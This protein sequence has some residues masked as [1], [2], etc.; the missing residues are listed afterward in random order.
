MTERISACPFRPAWATRSPRRRTR[1]QPSPG[2]PGELGCDR[3]GYTRKQLWCEPCIPR[4]PW[5]TL[6]RI[7]QLRARQQRR[8]PAPR[9][10]LLARRTRAA[11][12]LHPG[13]RGL[14][15]LTR[16]P[17][18]RRATPIFSVGWD[19]SA[20]LNLVP[21]GASTARRPASTSCCVGWCVADPRCAATSSPEL[22]PSTRSTGSVDPMAPRLADAL[23]RAL[24]VRRSPSVRRLAPE[25][26]SSS[27]TRSPSRAAST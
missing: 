17:C 23:A 9:T 7:C 15:P 25:E 11:I 4:L 18:C 6:E 24:P 19:M 20:T 21:G 10:Q 1:S 5:L 16:R 22:R 13:R 27:T 26:S 3:G 12:R 2:L 8:D 14:F